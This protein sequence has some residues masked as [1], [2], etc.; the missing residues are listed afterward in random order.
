MWVVSGTVSLVSNITQETRCLAVIQ[1][2]HF[3]RNEYSNTSNSNK[4]TVF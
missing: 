1:L 2:Y 4:N 3:P